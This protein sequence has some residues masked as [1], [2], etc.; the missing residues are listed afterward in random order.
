MHILLVPQSMHTIPLF[1]IKSFFQSIGKFP[2][3]KLFSI[4]D[5]MEFAL[6]ICGKAM[7]NIGLGL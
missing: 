3:T 2:Q 7:K 4:Q 6:C 5:G 1:I